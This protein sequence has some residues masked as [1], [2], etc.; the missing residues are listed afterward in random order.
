MKKLTNTQVI[1]VINELKNCQ[2][3]SQIAIKYN[4]SRVRI[5]KIK[6]NNKINK[7]RQPKWLSKKLNSMTERLVTRNI[8]TREL[9][10][11]TEIIRF[12]PNLNVSKRTIKRTLHTQGLSAK[13]K[14]RSYCCLKD[15][16]NRLDFE[17]A[18]RDWTIHDWR[19]VIF[20]DKRKLMDNGQMGNS[21]IGQEVIIT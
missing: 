11:A 18:H 19:Q 10:T 8:I 9:H 16:Q 7:R 14:L 20:S 3:L 2:L 15:K 5:Q 12:M 17:I 21:R 13:K 4:V 1:S 6:K